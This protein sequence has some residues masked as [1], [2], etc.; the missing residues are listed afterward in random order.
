LGILNAYTE[1]DY[2]ELVSGIRYPI[3]YITKILMTNRRKRDLTKRNQVRLSPGT[4]NSI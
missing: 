1:A 4:Q 2:L 3:I